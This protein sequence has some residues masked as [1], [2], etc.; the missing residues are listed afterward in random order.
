MDKKNELLIRVYLVFFAFV[1]FALLIIGKVVKTSLLEGDKW[2]EQGGKNIKWIEVAGERGNIYDIQGNLLATSLPYFDIYV[3]LV[4]SSEQ[5]FNNNIQALSK[6]LSIHFGKTPDEWRVKLETERNAGI[7]NKKP[8]SRYYPLLKKV[9]KDQLDLLKSFPLFKLGP[10]KGGLLY[11][12]KTSR[13]KPFKN[14]ASRTIGLDRKNASKIGIEGAFDSFLSGAVEKRLM[15]RLPGDIWLPVMDPEVISQDRGGDIVTTLDMHIQDIA[16]NELLAVLQ[17][18]NA[19]AGT[20]VIMDVETG[21]I[22][23]MSN[24]GKIE[25]GLYKEVYNYAVGRLSEPGSTFKLISAMALLEGGSVELDDEIFVNGG[26]KKFY[27]LWM[28]DS[29]MHG[30]STMTFQEVFEQSSNVGMANAAFE[31]YGKKS[32]WGEFVKA[33]R[34][35]GAGDKTGIKIAGE[36]TPFIKDPESFNTKG[37]N[38]WSGTTVPW[39][40]HGYELTM[41][42]LQ[43]LNIYNAVANDGRMMEPYIVKEIYE[44]GKCTKKI[45]PKVLNEN[46]ASPSTILKAQQLLKGVAESGTAKRL[47][48][49]DTSFAGKTGTT[50]LKYWESG[51]RKEYNASFAGYFPADNPKYSA[52]IVVYNPEGAY[53][54]SQVAGPIFKNIVQRMAGMEYHDIEESTQEEVHVIRAHSGYKNDFREVL[55][56]IGLGYKETG[57]NR[58]TDLET[59][60]QEV[61]MED[62]KILK[63]TVPN[64]KGMGLRDAVYVLESLGLNVEYSG[65]GK[66]YKQSVVPG[67]AI[68]GQTIRI[69][70]K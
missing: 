55:E 8:G 51:S 37:H 50:R 5:D 26:K 20:A 9:S 13:E 63:S 53:Y 48:V 66:V 45:T 68:N 39:M 33:I 21:A 52:M 30:K 24:L 18:Y 32:Q 43:V 56:Y 31:A 14:L 64:V 27:N 57:R 1:L 54:G 6:Q 12:R 67:T 16:H 4:T 40:A 59:K 2:R 62:K 23:A 47:K 10:N 69:Y 28:Y 29:E 15:R 58:W 17:K 65:L 38:N 41:T 34:S 11:E 46:I 7:K 36:E 70:L 3:D 49:E 61:A 60:S 35:I 19:D 44:D 42:P 25:E 22:K